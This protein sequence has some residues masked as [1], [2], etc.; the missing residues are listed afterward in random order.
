[1]SRDKMSRLS[2]VTSYE[3]CP[4]LSGSK[5]MVLFSRASLD[6]CGNRF[7]IASVKSVS[8]ILSSRRLSIIGVTH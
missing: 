3:G 5:T 2:I 6:N 1:V 4:K 8:D 7:F